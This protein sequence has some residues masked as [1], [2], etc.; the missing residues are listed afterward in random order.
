[1]A[2]IFSLEKGGLHDVSWGFYLEGIIDGPHILAG[3]IASPCIRIRYQVLI[4][5]RMP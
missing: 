2:K 5:K 4:V 3:K 1:M